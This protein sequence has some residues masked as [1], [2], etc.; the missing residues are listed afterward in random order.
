MSRH[1]YTEDIDDTWAHIRW[2]GA[3]SS[4]IRGKR[5]QAFLREMLA[6]LD[7]MPVKRL[8]A[9]ELQ[10]GGEF[11]AIGVVGKSR[12]VD[13]SDI[14]PEDAGAVARKFGISP[15]L[16]REIVYMNDEGL[17][18]FDE[19]SPERRWQKMRNWVASQITQEVT[20]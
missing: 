20:T 2:R 10:Q 12:G 18:V 4:A 19:I 6:E 15:A 5:G 17:Q 3:V 8:I 14:D 9:D 11:C 7:A 13:M 1:D 16:A